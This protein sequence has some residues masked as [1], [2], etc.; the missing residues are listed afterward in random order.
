[1]K[2]LKK[3][4]DIFILLFLLVV[5]AFLRI[6][7]IADYMTFLGD[8]G[9]DVLVVYDILHGHPTL[10]GPTMSVGG[11]FLGPIYYYLMTPFLWLYNYNPVGPAVMVALFGV[12]T[13]LLIY[14]IGSEFFGRTAGFVAAFLYS[15]SP[16]VI[17]Y[18]R[19]S[20]NPNI[21]AFFTLVTMYILYKALQ[22]NN[23]ILLAVSGLLYGICMQLHY[24]ELFIAP[25]IG[26]YILLARW[27]KDFNEK[28]VVKNYIVRIFKDG[29]T[30]F[31]G[32]LVGW[33]AFL[34]FE[35]R[36]GFP[37]THSIIKFV[38]STPDAAGNSNFSPV[39]SDVFFRL[40]GRLITKF[41]PPEQVSIPD[42]RFTLDL[43]AISLPLPIFILYLF[44]LCIAVFSMGYFGYLLTKTRKSDK[45]FYWYL[46]IFLWF[47]IGIVFFGFYKK[48]IYDYY[49]QFMFPLPFI[50]AGALFSYLYFK[51][52]VLR[53]VAIV[54]FVIVV[55]LN[56]SGIP[57]RYPANK[58]LEQAQTIAKFAYDKTNG[59][60]YNFAIGGEGN[61]DHAYRYFFT[62]WGNPPVE[63]QHQVDHGDPATVTEQLLIVCERPPCHPLGEAKWEIA[64][65]GRAEIAQEWDVSIARVY[66]L[67]HYKGEEK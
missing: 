33:S 47:V 48:S 36:H 24:V 16:L 8:E 12:A 32:F 14:L 59:K 7:R 22:K 4:K 38:F 2:I 43:F 35:F 49:F 26:V 54:F 58:Q 9:R 61:S 66:K 29:L 11:F 42:S 60:P 44:T 1:M 63:I 62:L 3:Y 6:Y 56:L 37:N 5:S 64:G 46:L 15:I 41:P 20:W 67:V 31:I 39:V 52:R 28:F 21:M 13:V 34:A 50:F 27:F 19:S 55:L 57:F 17:A 40:F 51:K 53:M 18:S 45:N 30:F 23:Y 10:L 25:T 65:F